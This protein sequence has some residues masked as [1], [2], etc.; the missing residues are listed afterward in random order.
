MVSDSCSLCGSEYSAEDNF[1]RFCGAELT[2]HV[3]Y[4]RTQPVDRHL[5][6]GVFLIA[7][8]GLT[9]VASLVVRLTPTLALGLSC[10]LIGIMTLYLPEPTERLA[11][12]LASDSSIPLMLNLENLLNDLAMNEKGVYVP[13]S[14]LGVCPKVFV[15]LTKTGRSRKPPRNLNDSRRVFITLDEKTREGGLLLEAPGRN[16]LS[17][18]ELIMS[19]DFSKSEIGALRDKLEQ[20]LKILEISRSVMLEKRGDRTFAVETELDT[21][22]ELEAKLFKLTPRVADQ[23]GTPVV[24]A[25]AAAVSKS[26]GQYIMLKDLSMNPANRKITTTLEAVE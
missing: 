19:T 20:G 4:K 24:S 17:E 3:E 8:G 26:T 14:G 22:G 12:R 15:P 25:I 7:F 23:I 2:H 10:L 21:L 6:V 13:V 11:E 5:S 18:L 1:C 9:A 16:L